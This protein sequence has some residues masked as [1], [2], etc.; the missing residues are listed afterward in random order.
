[1][2]LL[3]VPA[4]H[5]HINY[6]SPSGRLVRDRA[7]LHAEGGGLGLISA[8]QTA[9]DARLG[10]LLLT[11]HLVAQ[12]LGPTFDPA[13]HGAAAMPDLD[14]LLAHPET[15]ALRLPQ[16]NG[17]STKDAFSG[18]L[19]H[20][21]TIL[22][23]ARRESRLQAVLSQI[24]EPEAKAWL[25]SC[26]AEGANFLMA[27]KG[28]LCESCPSWPTTTSRPWP[29]PAWGCSPPLT[30]QYQCGSSWALPSR[31]PGG[32]AHAAQ[33]RAATGPLACAGFTP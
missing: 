17:L 6:D 31:P 3:G 13:Q 16:L 12:A 26:G 28:A 14:A 33:G 20:M 8:S 2:D 19:P 15:R 25:L 29:G 10:N 23:H 1:M 11:A 21:S 4:G 18:P 5:D 24:Q 22:S 7:H 27:D 30:R 9:S 32:G